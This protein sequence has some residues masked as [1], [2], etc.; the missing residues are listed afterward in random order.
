MH[1]A[2]GLHEY[3]ERAIAGRLPRGARVL[4]VG[5]GSGALTARLTAA[6]YEVVASDLETQDYRAA[7]PLVQ[8]DVA[9]NALPEQ[10]TRDSFECVCV[11]EVLE[12][13]EN[14]LQALRNV[15][16]LLKP[17]GLIVA[18]TPHIG[19]PRSRLKFFITGVPSYFGKAE[20]SADG[21]RTLLPDWLLVRHLEAVGFIGVDVSYAGQM[22]LP[23]KSRLLWAV[24]AP[25]LPFLQSRPRFDDGCITVAV[26]QRP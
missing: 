4:D 16:T 14:P 7:A 10:L 23:R 8:W 17:G 5:A 21:H 9:A 12:H 19:H 24:T 2:G 3:V 26:A 13:V 15:I 1:A 18:T 20:Y 25:L 6:G 22:G 11:I